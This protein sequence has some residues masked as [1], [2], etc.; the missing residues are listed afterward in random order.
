M[1]KIEINVEYTR[2][3]ILLTT[4]HNG[5]YYHKLYMFYSLKDAKQE[6]R[7]YVKSH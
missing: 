3:G 1:E 4:V 5:Q 7:E 2:N 6:F